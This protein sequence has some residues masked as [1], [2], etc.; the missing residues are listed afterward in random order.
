MTR[1]MNQFILAMSYR[2]V[3]PSEHALPE[4][5]HDEGEQVGGHEWGEFI[6]GLLPTIVQGLRVLDR[7]VGQRHEVWKRT[8]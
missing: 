7:H 3:V 8:G 1:T 2:E 4:V 6:A 5:S